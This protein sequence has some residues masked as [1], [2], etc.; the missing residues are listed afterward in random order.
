MR[1]NFQFGDAAWKARYLQMLISCGVEKEDIA[2][3][4]DSFLMIE[5]IAQKDICLAT[6]AEAIE[7]LTRLS[8][9]YP[10]YQK[11]MSSYLNDYIAWRKMFTPYCSESLQRA[12]IENSEEMIKI[13]DVPT[14]PEELELIITQTLGEA[15]INLAAPCLCLAWL[16]YEVPDMTTLKETDLDVENGKLCGAP[17]PSALLRVLERYRTTDAE[18]TMRGRGE[19]WMYKAPGQWLVRPTERAKAGGGASVPYQI[20]MAVSGMAKKYRKITGSN[21]IVSLQLAK[22]AGMLYRIYVPWDEFTDENFV[23]AL[24]FQKRA[25]DSYQMQGWRRTFTAYCLLKENAT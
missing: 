3:L 5:D 24:R 17:V 22:Q 14:N 15:T 10:E 20:T 7:G 21:R 16:G 4:L 18:Q 23:K 2:I 25:Y 8:Q 11:K 13:K 19:S 9:V 6:A 12:E 1:I